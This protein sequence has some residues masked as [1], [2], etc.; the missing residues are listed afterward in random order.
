M[1]GKELFRVSK[2]LSLVLRH[3]PG[4][5]GVMLDSNGYVSVDVLLE[6]LRSK[7]THLTL[8]NLQ[9]L[10]AENNKQRFAFSADGTRIRASQGHSVEVDLGYAPKS[11][12][13]LLYHGTA[14]RF[15]TSIYEKG[16]LKGARNHVHLSKDKATAETVGKRH[17]TP[18]IFEVQAEAM[19]RDGFQFYL[20]DNGVWLTEH[21]P[22][23]YLR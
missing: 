14:T 4:H 18:H 2:L 8:E 11:P 19:V 13:E 9:K 10:V 3:D 5:I 21:V 7:G 20:S 6:R 23:K 12:P 15:M 1:N 22:A 16:L 17:G